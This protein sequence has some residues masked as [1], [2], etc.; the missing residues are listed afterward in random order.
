MDHYEELGLKRTATAQEIR[1]AYKVMARLVHPDGHADRQVKE[2]AQRQM[3]RLNE[4]LAMLTN[5]QTRREYDAGLAG[6]SMAELT[7]RGPAAM[8]P[9]AVPAGAGALRRARWGKR[10]KGWEAEAEPWTAGLPG[11]AQSAV[12]NG[13]WISL[14][15]VLVCVGVWYMAQD[16]GGSARAGSPPEVKPVTPMKTRVPRQ[17]ARKEPDMEKMTEPAIAGDDAAAGTEPVV[18]PATPETPA[19]A[20]AP[21]AQSSSRE[22]GVTESASDHPVATAAQSAPSNPASAPPKMAPA[23][24][25]P[26]FAGTW[27]YVPDPSDSAAPG[28]YPATYAEFLLAEAH[29]QLS[30]SYRANYRVADRAVSPEVSFHVEG[31]T[32]AGKSARL[33]WTSADGAKGEVD[34]ALVEPN[35]MTVSWWSTELGRHATLASGTAKLIRQR[36]R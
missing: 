11:W 8:R 15:L 9:G 31:A 12:Q 27:L 28:A 1:Q 18:A 26:T 6:A 20:E 4:I 5:E 32:P 33:R 13:F 7:G 30:G 10:P 22:T 35:L 14:V 3:Q 2:M 34:M 16:T 25:A 29:G 24:E 23:T 19:T 17:D 21:P 36:V